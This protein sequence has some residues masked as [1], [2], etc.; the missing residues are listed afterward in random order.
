[1]R[2]ILHGDNLLVPEIP[3]NGLA[4]FEHLFCKDVSS[5]EAIKHPSNNQFFQKKGFN[6]KSI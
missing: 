6:K 2:P 3:E 1:M 4:Y 5:S